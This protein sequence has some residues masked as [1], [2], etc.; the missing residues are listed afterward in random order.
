MIY[1]RVIALGNQQSSVL[2]LI[3][4]LSKG[5][6]LPALSKSV[7]LSNW[8]KISTRFLM[9]CEAL[10]Q[11]VMF[12]GRKKS[13]SF[14]RMALVCPSSHKGI[15]VTRRGNLV[16][17]FSKFSIITSIPL[18]RLAGGGLPNMVR[19]VDSNMREL[20]NLYMLWLFQSLSSPGLCPR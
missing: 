12:C 3:T 5:P 15:S 9:N 1:L 8:S 16:S 20:Q 17:Y 18:W 7:R 2:L 4:G 13:V 11:R 19:S 14:S 10:D 6:C